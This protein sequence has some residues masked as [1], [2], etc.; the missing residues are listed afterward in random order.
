[1]KLESF[2][3]Y[4][5]PRDIWI[6]LYWDRAT[7]MGPYYQLRVYLCLLPCWPIRI[8]LNYPHPDGGTL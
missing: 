7:M 4:F 1:M 3:I 2:R 6:G 5:E 8:A